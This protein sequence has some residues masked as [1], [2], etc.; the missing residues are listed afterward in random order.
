L[1]PSLEREAVPGTVDEEGMMVGSSSFNVSE[2]MSDWYSLRYV[3]TA[4]ALST[5]AL[6]ILMT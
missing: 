4:D 6:E 1:I 3:M 2:L 5:G